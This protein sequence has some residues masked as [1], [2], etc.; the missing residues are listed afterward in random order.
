MIEKAFDH[1]RN[2]LNHCASIFAL[3]DTYSQRHADQIDIKSTLAWL[4]EEYNNR[5]LVPQNITA[6]YNGATASSFLAIKQT[7][8][9]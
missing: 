9:Y 2:T 7:I 5:K 1:C 6:A 8:K 4:E 3:I